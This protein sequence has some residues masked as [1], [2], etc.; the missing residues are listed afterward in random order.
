MKILL[1]GKDGQVGWELQRA[2]APLC[3]LI[4]V[5]REQV[6]L[7][8]PTTLREAIR[9]AKPEVIVNAAAYTRV[10]AAESEPEAARSVNALAPGVMAEE[11]RRLGAALLHYSTDYV[12]DGRAGRPYVEE[13]TPNPLSV[14]GKTKLE[15]EQAI[16]AAGPGHLILRTSWVYSLRRPCF[17][18][19]ILDGARQRESLRIASDQVGSPTWCRL[20][21]VATA[22]ILV[23]A[24]PGPREFLAERAGLYHLA[25]SGSAPRLDWAREILRLDPRPEEQRVRAEDIREGRSSEFAVPAPRP[26]FSALDSSR[27]LKDFGIALPPWRDALRLAMDPAA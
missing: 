13:D 4:A 1:I 22:M 9:S 25:C 20:L 19:S 8:R 23:P 3:D 14:Y 21:A 5:G 6:G 17:V 27:A 16:R 10:D 7:E 11:A 18:R 15:G 24:R 26:A 2:L 12:F